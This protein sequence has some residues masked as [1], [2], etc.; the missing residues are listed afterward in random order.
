[1]SHVPSKPRR[2]TLATV[3]ASAGVSVATVSKVVNGRSDVAPATRALVEDVL[4]RYEYPPVPRR[5]EPAPPPTI[6]VTFDRDLH[7]YSSEVAH[8][9]IDAGKELGVTVVLSIH[10]DPGGSGR[11]RRPSEWAHDIAATGRAALIAVTGSLTSAHIAAL[12][13]KRIPLVVVDPLHVPHNRIVS[14]GSTNFAGGLAAGEHLL[15]LGHTRIGYAGGPT[16]ASCNRARIAGLRSVVEA[17]GQALPERYVRFGEYL[18]ESGLAAGGELLDLPDRPTAIFAGS[19]EMALGVIEA[20]RIRTLR[21]PQDLSIVGFDD[22]QLARMASPPLTTVRQ[23]LHEMGAV[24]VR[25]ALRMVKGEDLDSHHVELAT[26][27]VVRDSTATPAAD[28]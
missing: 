15:T 28:L 8:G 1:M 27:L 21:V 20:A 4:R 2:V 5:A 13:L 19:D 24:A 22:T 23:P 10:A 18:Y 16:S 17:A 7:A 11:G 25:T 26:E 3:A 9:A 14:I 12:R 6:E